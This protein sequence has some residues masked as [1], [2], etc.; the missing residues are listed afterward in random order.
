[1]RPLIVE[2]TNTESNTS[3]EGGFSNFDHHFKLP[4]MFEA[5]LMQ[6]ASSQKGNEPKEDPKKDREVGKSIVRSVHHI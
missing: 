2:V 6:R 3:T 1:M 5:E 4:M